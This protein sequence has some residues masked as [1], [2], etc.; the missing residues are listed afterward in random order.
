MFN[1]FFLSF[2]IYEIE[3]IN[4]IAIIDSIALE[5]KKPQNENHQRNRFITTTAAAA[6]V[7][8]TA[9]STYNCCS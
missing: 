9:M 3:S 6:A 4:Q 2:S 1:P 8:A 7:T 5:K